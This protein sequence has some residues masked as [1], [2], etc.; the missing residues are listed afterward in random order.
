MAK[1]SAVPAKPALHPPLLVSF[2]CSTAGAMSTE[3]S[4]LSMSKA[5]LSLTNIVTL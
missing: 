5:P 1:I 4:V 2:D 3:P